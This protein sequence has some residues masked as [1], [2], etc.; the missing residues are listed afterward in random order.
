MTGQNGLL[1]GKKL[2]ITCEIQSQVFLGT[3]GVVNF[4]KSAIGLFVLTATC[5]GANASKAGTSG[6][7][8]DM[9][10]LLNESHPFI[11]TPSSPW[12]FGAGRTVRAPANPQSDAPP[13]VVVPASFE[14]VAAHRGGSNIISEI[15][16]GALIHDEG[17]FSHR[18][19]GGYDGSLE[20]IFKSP[21]FLK[22]VWEPRPHLGIQINSQGD[23]HQAYLGLSWEWEFFKSAFFG[24]SLGGA[25][26]TGETETEELDKKSLGCSVLFRESLDLGY[27][28]NDTHA[29]M[30]HLNHISNAK[31]CS[32]N[33]GLESFGIRYGYKF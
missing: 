1:M 9:S 7:I 30:V 19:E 12:P 26:H 15:R 4:L 11:N 18:K 16:L 25:Y 10:R 32:T 27:R 29:L 31:L 2:Q 28:F 5:F 17:P 22:S 24:F 23:T 20:F 33:E 8:Y 13:P 14:P 3:G 21:D 6:G